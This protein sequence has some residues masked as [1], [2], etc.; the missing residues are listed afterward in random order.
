MSLLNEIK[1]SVIEP[2]HA[3]APILLKLRLL[4]SRL[5]SAPLEAWVKHESEGYPSNVEVPRYRKLNV[6]YLASFSGPFGSGIKN[7]PIPS[8]L[9]QDYAGEN[10]LIHEFRESIAA[11]E[12]L[13]EPKKNSGGNI[14]TNASNLILLLQDKV[15]E[16]YACNSVK[17]V[18]STAAL[19]EIQNAVRARV[20]DL[21]IEIEKSIPDAATISLGPLAQAPVFKDVE[22][23]TKITQQ[24]IYGDLN[25]FSTTGDNAQ[26]NINIT[27]GD[28]NAFVKALEGAGIDK[29]DAAELAEI[30]SAE[31]GESRDEPF[32]SKAKAWFAKNI[33]KAAD[34][35][36]K[37]VQ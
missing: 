2:G 17:G 4:A 10:W 6:E 37:V 34:G 14:Y 16:N 18:I 36:W 21:T 20:L 30:V 28:K 19:I 15:Y 35:T 9:I 1:A 32:G 33:G 24:I 27:S 23:V 22:A 29:S 8:Y 5:G 12:Q 13:I 3:I 11:V 25:A 26:F 31:K 7:A